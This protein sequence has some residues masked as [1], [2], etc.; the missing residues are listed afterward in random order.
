MSLLRAIARRFKRKPTVWCSLCTTYPG[1]HYRGNQVL[2]EACL[3]WL[4]ERKI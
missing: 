3:I 2:C 1:R 4:N